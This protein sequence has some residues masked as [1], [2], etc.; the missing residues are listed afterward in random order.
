VLVTG[1]LGFTGQ[2]VARRLLAD[3]HH[4]VALTSS[5][6]PTAPVPPGAELRVA[7]LRDA[8]AVARATAGIDAVCHLAALTR[9]RESADDPV[10]YFDV[11]VGGT[12][13]LLR[14]LERQADAVPTVVFCSSGAVYGSREGALGES[15][16]PAPANPYATSKLAAEHVI[17]HLASTGRIAA[18][19][20]RCFNIAGAVDGL[21]D[22]DLTRIIPRTLAVAAGQG[23]LTINGDGSAVREYTHVTDV[24][25]AFARAL[26]H[27][28]PGRAAVYNV[29]SGRGVTL[30]EVVAVAE[31]V[32]G[33]P[34]ERE[35]RP[36][37]PE[38]RVLMAD[39]SRI[40]AELGWRPERSSLEQILSDGWAAVTR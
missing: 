38:A 39:S 36:P 28:E 5:P 2:A 24:A 30:A 33:R 8:A 37:R 4:V 22:R 16:P 34:V 26:E 17:A 29:G 31:Q 13:N 32:T 9:V 18:V 14:A 35:H 11:N 15:E 3:K 1:A 7:D 19:T 21:G 25:A 20:L 27:A 10:R 12:L 6:A 40:R 23:R